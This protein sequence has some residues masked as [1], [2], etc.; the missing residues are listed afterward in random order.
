MSAPDKLK[1]VYE[2]QHGKLGAG[3]ML[4]TAVS[5]TPLRT[6]SS[7][8]GSWWRQ[9]RKRSHVI[10]TANEKARSYKLSS[11]MHDSRTPSFTW[12]ACSML[13]AWHAF[14]MTATWR[15]SLYVSSCT[16]PACRVA[17][18]CDIPHELRPLCAYVAAVESAVLPLH[19][20]Q[21]TQQCHFDIICRSTIP[22]AQPRLSTCEEALVPPGQT[23]CMRAQTTSP[24][25]PSAT[26]PPCYTT[27]ST[28]TALST[29]GRR[30]W[31]H[32]AT[33]YSNS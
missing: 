23:I 20:L 17:V 12:A 26:H 28:Q 30:A 15:T 16:G 2:L 29:P 3:L 21:S 14:G 6:S 8:R 4:D 7:L 33:V 10:F 5:A 13:W 22:V 19:R 27:R 32:A 9:R 25:Q 31:C 18:P 1:V 24:P 11:L